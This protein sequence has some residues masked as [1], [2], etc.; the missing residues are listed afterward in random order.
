MKVLRERKYL[1]ALLALLVVFAACKGESPTAPTAGGGT[2]GGGSVGGGTPP[3]GATITLTVSNANPLVN[4]TSVVTATVS[5]NNN[6]VPN[7]TAVEFQTTG[8]G[9]VP[10]GVW[11]DSGLPTTI[12]TTT[13]GVATATLTSGTPGAAVVTAIVNNVTRQT[14]VTFQTSPTTVTPPSTAPT[15]TSINPTS[16]KVTGGEILT[17]NGTNFRTPVR[18]LFDLGG[19]VVKE[20]FVSSVTA[21]QIQ[22]LTPQVTLAGVQSLDAT[23]ILLNEAGTSAETRITAPGTFTFRLGTLTPV[24]STVSPDSGPIT[25]GTRI[26][27]FGSGFEAPVQVSFAPGGSN[28]SSGWSQI[29]VISITFN[30]IVAITPAARDVNPTGSGTLV[31]AVDLRVRNITSNTEVVKAV[32]FRYTPAMQITGA[33]P[34]AGSSLGGTDVTI[35]GIGFDDPV[36]VF[37]GGILAQTIR[38]SGTQILARTNALAIPCASSSGP[39]AVTN[40]NNGDSAISPVTFGYIGVPSIITSV[41]GAPIIPGSTITVDVQNPGV[42]LLGN[43]VIRFSIGGQNVSPTPSQITSGTGIQT[44]TMVVPTTGFT[45]PTVTCQTAALTP[46]TQLGTVTTSIIF[47]NATTGCVATVDGVVINPPLPNTCLAPPTATVVFPV[48]PACTSA[49]AVVAAGAVTSN[50]TITISNAPSSRDL[51]VIP[52]VTCTNTTTCT[53]TP[54]GTTTI[55]G[56]SS[57]SWTVT[58]DPTAV[59]AVTGTATFTTNDPTKASITVCITGSGT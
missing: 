47:T 14:T 44:F 22:V 11:Q 2:G 51:T 21:T 33:R 13:N 40:I 15:I 58:V 48:A 56:G 32:I 45:F 38:V 53:I 6:P 24:V 41:G 19:G 50:A 46:G 12:R 59:G 35:D 27:I 49:P 54:L 34:L 30:Q 39:I 17:L 8:A 20:G 7:G 37:I 43:A 52:T 26:T 5:Q 31:G 36:D 25:G 16:G 9:G 28:G 1:I 29:Q 23:V 55:A 57:V 42:G 10:F 3:S 4:S 18:V